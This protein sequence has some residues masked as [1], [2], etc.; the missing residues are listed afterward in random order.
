MKME[1][2]LTAQNVSKIDFQKQIYEWERKSEH[3]KEI[4][5]INAES[6]VLL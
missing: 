4:N 6:K 2:H 5:F 3:K 1:R